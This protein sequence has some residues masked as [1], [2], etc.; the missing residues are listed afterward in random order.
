M[1][2]LAIFGP[3]VGQIVGLEGK[4]TL[5]VTG[6]TRRMWS[7]GTVPLRLAVLSGSRG[8]F[9]PKKV[10]LGHKMRSFGRAP[11]DLLP[12]PRGATG[13]FW[14]KTW[15]WQGHHLGNRIRDVGME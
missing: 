10:V 14:L 6:H 5:F 9:A 2:F 7:V 13:D 15:I 11:A 12:P 3:F 4:K 1:P 8:R